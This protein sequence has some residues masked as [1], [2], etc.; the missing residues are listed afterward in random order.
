MDTTTSL[1]VSKIEKLWRKASDGAATPAEREA[2]EAKALSLMEENRITMAMLEIDDED[3]LGD[4]EYGFIKG[5][6]SR[7]EINVIDAVARAYDCRV[8][9]HSLYGGGKKVMLF[10]FKSDVERVK[11]MAGMLVNLAKTEA[12]LEKGVDAGHT[13]SLRHSFIAGFA[14]AIRTRLRE[15]AHLAN[16]AFDDHEAVK[17]AELVLVSRREQMNEKY[18]QKKLHNAGGIRIGNGSSYGRGRVAGEKASLS[19]QGQVANRRELASA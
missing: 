14:Q 10:G 18:A 19:T 8:W 7:V 17:G 12:A 9:W 11:L 6:Y 1:L 5:R 4:Y 2:F 15:A 3:I 16:R 13:F